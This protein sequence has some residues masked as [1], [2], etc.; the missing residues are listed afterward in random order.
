MVSRIEYI[1]SLAILSLIFFL[2]ILKTLQGQ[3][4]K[5]IAMVQRTAFLS[6]YTNNNSLETTRKERGG[7]NIKKPIT[8]NTPRFPVRSPVPS[9]PSSLLQ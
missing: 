5:V 2:Y 3:A 4:L 8:R 6:R 9:I 1:Y 7:I